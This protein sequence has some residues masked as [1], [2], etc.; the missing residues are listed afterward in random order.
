MILIGSDFGLCCVC[1][2]ARTSVPPGV[3]WW[4]AH[5]HEMTAIGPEA[6]CRHLAIQMRKADGGSTHC[7]SRNCRPLVISYYAENESLTP[8]FNGL[9]DRSDG[10][11]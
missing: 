5:L 4:Q 11:S 1:G 6:A 3:G 2:D 7:R 8:E 9:A 10:P